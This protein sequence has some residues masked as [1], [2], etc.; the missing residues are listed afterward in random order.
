MSNRMRWLLSQT[1]IAFRILS[2]SSFV[3]FTPFGSFHSF[4]SSSQTNPSYSGTPD[5]STYTSAI[6]FLSLQIKV[7]ARP[8]DFHSIFG[9]SFISVAERRVHTR[10]LA[11]SA[12]RSCMARLVRNSFFC[13]WHRLQKWLRQ[14][15]N[16]ARL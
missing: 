12:G 7:A 14:F 1:K 15:G 10:R 11:R 5:I 16:L 8:S 3:I 4:R 2:S 9:S 13:K 6:L